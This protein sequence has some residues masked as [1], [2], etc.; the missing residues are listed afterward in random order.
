MRNV[1]LWAYKIMW[2]VSLFERS[3][4]WYILKNK[5]F[6]RVR[7]RNSGNM[8][9]NESL[10]IL[11]PIEPARFL[12]MIRA[13]VKEELDKYSSRQLGSN[14]KTSGLTYKP[15]YKMDEVCEIFNVTSPTIYDWIKHGKLKPKK[16]RSRVFFL[17]NDME[18]LQ[19]KQ[20][21]TG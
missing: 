18:L 2:Y 7:E 19:E 6:N 13:V 16:V 8:Q 5:G 1:I 10:P 14:Y 9:N 20:G 21:K 4:I 11:V 12:E 15:L 17:W 3:F